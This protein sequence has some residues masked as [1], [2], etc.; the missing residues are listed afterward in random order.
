[1]EV[2]VADM[3]KIRLQ[4]WAAIADKLPKVSNGEQ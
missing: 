3:D 1:V 4:R 2:S